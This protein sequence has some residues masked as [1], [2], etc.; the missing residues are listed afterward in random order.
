[1]SI[2]NL[3]REPGR[4][5]LSEQ[6]DILFLYVKLCQKYE[7]TMRWLENIHTYIYTVYMHILQVEVQSYTDYCLYVYKY[8]ATVYENVYSSRTD[9]E[10]F[11]VWGRE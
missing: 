7:N 5:V 3:P 2:K 8:L 4:E 10:Q 6:T 1:M 11:P 9:E